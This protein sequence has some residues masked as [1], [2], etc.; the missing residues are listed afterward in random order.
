MA[1]TNNEE[2]PKP[3]PKGTDQCN[4]EKRQNAQKCEGCEEDIF[5]MLLCTNLTMKWRLSE[6]HKT[7]QAILLELQKKP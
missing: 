4:F 5:D 7:M 2:L 3:N 1:K 6:I